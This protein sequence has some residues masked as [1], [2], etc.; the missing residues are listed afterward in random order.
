V[1]IPILTALA[2]TLPAAAA[3]RAEDRVRKDVQY[4]TAGGEP[5]RLDVFLPP[6]PETAAAGADRTFPT[7]VLLHGGGWQMGDKSNC[8]PEA[9]AW[10]D[11]GLVCVCVQYR[12]TPRHPFPAQIDDVRAAVRFLRSHAPEYRIDPDR[13][14]AVGWSAGGHLAMLAGLADPDPADKPGEPSGRVR[15]VISFFA[16][17]DLRSL[18]PTAEAR[19]IIGKVYKKDAEAILTDFLGTA[20]RSAAA[21]AKASP[22]THVRPGVA[23]VLSIV[24]TAD[25]F[26]PLAQPQALHE[27]LRKAG[28]AENLV[29]VEGGGHDHRAW[30]KPAQEKVAAAAWEFLERHLGF[31]PTAWPVATEY[32][33]VYG[34]GGDADLKLDLARPAVGAG[35]FPLLLWIHGGA[36]CAGN[37]ADLRLPIR[38]FAKR[39][40]VCASVGYRLAPKDRFPA[41]IED[42]KCALRFLRSKAA[43]LRIDPDRVGAVGFSAGGHLALLMGLTSPADG[44]EGSG[45]H[46]DKA[47]RVQAVVNF[48]GPTDL[49]A[50]TLGGED[51]KTF[52]A[53]IGTDVDGLYL[54]FLGTADRTAEIM[55]RA[56][57][58]GYVDASDPPVL[59]LHGTKDPIVPADQARRLHEALRKAGV[60]ERLELIEGA[61]HGWGGADLDRSV[62]ITLEFLD[63]HLRAKKAG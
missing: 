34:K 59:T 24:G 17:C 49:P 41:Q 3:A 25:P 12:F 45:G 52:R 20:D 28:V 53:A 9:R 43:D 27:A 13:I 63:R 5:L 1:L 48:Y 2:A 36:W 29:V 15:A 31:V 54:K 10:S 55:R 39:G 62:R 42:V 47:G 7:L 61:G 51:A 16:A 26:I 23:P 11:L 38:E 22:I 33:V 57:P 40:Y 56:S 50:F 21:F 32:D 19:E 6:R 60:T 44:L 35:P 18:T 4:S 58:V 46:A 30:P 14:G 8:H 37:K